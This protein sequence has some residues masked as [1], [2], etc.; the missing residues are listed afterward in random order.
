MNSSGTVKSSFDNRRRKHSA[1]SGILPS[2]G[3][4][5]IPKSSIVE[6]SHL[7]NSQ[8]AS[9]DSRDLLSNPNSLTKN[10]KSY[11]SGTEKSSHSSY[12]S[13]SHEPKTPIDSEQ[14]EDN[15]FNLSDFAADDMESIKNPSELLL[16]EP[17]HEMS[18][19]Y[20]SVD[21]WSPMESIDIPEYSQYDMDNYR[22]LEPSLYETTLLQ[23]DTQPQDLIE[24]LPIERRISHYSQDPLSFLMSQDK[25]INLHLQQNIKS[26]AEVSKKGLSSKS[27]R[28]NIENC[29]KSLSSVYQSIAELYQKEQKRKSIILKSFEKWEQNKKILNEKVQDIRSEN[30]TEG[31]RL[32]QLLKESTTV[33]E[34]IESLEKRLKQLKEKKKVLGNEIAQ[35]QSIIESRSSSYLESL[36]EIEK[37]EKNAIIKLSHERSIESGLSNSSLG[38]PIGNNTRQK[39]GLKN[40]LRSFSTPLDS[41]F[42]EVDAAPVIELIERQIDTFKDCIDDYKLKETSYEEAFI[43]WADISTILN[44]LETTIYDILQQ[45]GSSKDDIKSKIVDNL[46]QTQ[47]LLIERLDSINNMNGQLK[48]LIHTEISILD[49]GIKMIQPDHKSNAPSPPDDTK[50][51]QVFAPTINP[52]VAKFSISDKALASSPPHATLAVGSGSFSS[53]GTTLKSQIKNGLFKKDV[54]KDKEKQTKR[55]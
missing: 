25:V 46:T 13:N 55:D 23:R 8:Q 29:L 38:F 18:E 1:D 10:N 53:S 41:T 48:S 37:V 22:S 26:H 45:N 52:T 19:L 51:A 17:A 34:E 3:V 15:N 54:T 14:Q 16:Y 6:E 36:R 33:D 2:N 27:I 5:A 7:S 11:Q 44:G 21:N 4:D 49:M 50:E 32:T 35:S 9:L 28:H 20:D 42:D 39:F 40:F 30:N 43:I 31:Y 47:K 12:R 24:N